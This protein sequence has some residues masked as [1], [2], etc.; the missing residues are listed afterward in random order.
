MSTETAAQKRKQILN[1]L[2]PDSFLHCSEPVLKVTVWGLVLEEKVFQMC[3][4]DGAILGML[5][6]L[7]TNFRLS[8]TCQGVWIRNDKVEE[9]PPLM[10]V[11]SSS[12]LR[13]LSLTWRTPWSIL[14]FNLLDILVLKSTAVILQQLYL[15][16]NMKWLDK[17]L[18]WNS[19]FKH[20]TFWSL[21]VA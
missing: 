4:S 17:F 13:A 19:A 16:T 7:T 3:W 8:L 1:V 6:P 5:C 12:R 21:P 20:S 18:T 14:A 15:N 9:L 2:C 10:L 11:N